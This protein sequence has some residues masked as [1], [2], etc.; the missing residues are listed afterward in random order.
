[1]RKTKIVCTLGPASE[2]RE[3]IQRLIESG[4]NVAR[5]NFSHGTYPEHKKK[6]DLVKEVSRELNRPVAIMLDTKGPEIRIR[7]FSQGKILLAKGDPFTLTA[8]EILG[9][10]TRV[11]ITYKNLVHE[12]EPGNTILA[13]DGLIQL[14][15]TQVDGNEIHCVV[16]NGGELSNNK[17]LNFPNINIKLPAI[18]EKDR[19]DII[20]GIKEGVDYIAASFVR[21]RDDV[22]SIRKVLEDN[23]GEHIH[24]ISKIE[25][26]EGLDNIDQIIE[27]SDGIMVARGD[28]GVEV[29]PEEVPLAQKSIIQKCN[30][31]G[32]PVITATQMLDSMIR[33]PRPTRAEVTDVANAIFDGTD[34]IMLSGETAAGRYPVESVETM[35]R[36]AAKTEES[37]AF[38][39][40][41]ARHRF[42]GEVSVTNVISHSTCSTAEQLH[43]SAIV[44]ATSSGHTARMVSKFRPSAPIIAITDDGRVQRK[45]SL[46]WGVQCLVTK[47]FDNTDTL[48]EESLLIGVEQGVL[49]CGDLVVIS[50][51]VPLGVKGTTNLLKVQTI[52]NVLLN[53]SGIGKKGVTATARVTK[54]P[55]S[56]FN[57][58]DIMV[59]NGVDETNIHFAKMAS[60]IITEEGGYTSQGAIAAL[61]F[62]IPI[63][64]GVDEAT[65]KIQDGSVITIDPQGGYIY[66]GKARV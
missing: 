4:M 42:T 52:G 28:L 5:L 7:Q 41:M 39:L 54:D 14:T 3:M 22:L 30:E 26:R 59:V 16:E 2:T 63:I 11:S 65:D 44:T 51:G 58:G 17:S 13:D 1:M 60:G 19:E 36:I 24:I 48:F 18:T 33:N 57:E 64:L 53:G 49:H 23:E 15:V 47:T 56:M 61:Q 32:K 55:D 43:A 8:E 50:A 31:V 27:V 45:L 40:K 21:R 62:K 34:A 20:F 25:N 9:D 35:N 37:E 66:Q 38:L 6:I 10:Q 46:V 29:S 12:V